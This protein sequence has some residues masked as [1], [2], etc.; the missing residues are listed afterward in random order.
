MTN[1]LSFAMKKILYTCV[2]LAAFCN[3]Q[4]YCQDNSSVINNAVAGLKSLSGNHVIEKAYLHFD[5]PYY[6]VG[7]TMRFKAYLTLGEHYDLSRLSGILHVD[8][9]SPDN[10]IFR[11]IKLQIVNGIGWGDFPLPFALSAGNYRVRAYTN[12]MQNA[13]EYFFDKTIAIGSAMN[14]GMA[15]NTSEQK[16]KGDL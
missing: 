4:A 2:F 7:D 5:K 13:P 10:S 16:E 8:L 1:Q 9:I 12:Y 3:L 14:T 11:S 6:A 15:S